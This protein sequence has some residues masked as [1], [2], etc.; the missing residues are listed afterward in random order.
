MARLRAWDCVDS[1]AGEVDFPGGDMGLGVQMADH[2]IARHGLARTT[3]PNDAKDFTRRDVVRDAVDG[4][5]DAVAGGD[6]DG[7]VADGEDG[8]SHRQG[9]H[10]GL[11]STDRISS[12]SAL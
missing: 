6:I 11:R 9:F 2:G 10:K 1:G 3:F 5:Q 7:E 4:S 12:M 8:G